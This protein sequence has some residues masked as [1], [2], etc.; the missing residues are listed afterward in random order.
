[1]HASRFSS[2][3]IAVCAL[4]YGDTVLAI[5]GV[6]RAVSADALNPWVSVDASGS[7]VATITPF[8][9]SVN[10]VATTIGAAPASL[11]ATTTSQTDDKPTQTSGAAPKSTG[12]GSFQV[13]NN[14]KGP[15]A[16]FCKPENGSSVYVGETYYVTW[17]PNF[18]PLK[19]SSVKIQANYVNQSDGGL[20]AFQSPD[21]V[22]GFGFLAW[23]IDKEMLRD[24]S[25]NNVTLFITFLNI[26]HTQSVQGP[27][28]QVTNRPKEY[29]R[30]E[31]T[32]APKGH[33][34]YIALPTVFG[35]IILCVC[36]TFFLNRKKRTI[37]LGNI[38]GRRRGYGVGKSRAQRMGSRMGLG[39]KKKEEGIRLREQE[40][41]ADGQY[42]DVPADRE[43]SSAGHTR[44][45]SDTLGSLAE[46]PSEERTNYFRDERRQQDQSRY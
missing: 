9:T 35:F 2:S 12:G 26:D 30:Q 44:S 10:G 43:R 19:N 27:T 41:T 31:P 4:F 22:N 14:M 46:S 18:F 15:F 32:K 20:Q 8:P 25:S 28:L 21:T 45:D 13:C 29:F 11:T 6:P 7:P 42:R 1:M 16:P 38:M 37:G 36:G 3:V 24:K 39:K 34:L 23:T 40:L 5:P 33:S 17:D